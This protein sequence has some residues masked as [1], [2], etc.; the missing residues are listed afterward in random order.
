[1]INH[2]GNVKMLDIQSYVVGVARIFP[3]GGHWGAFDFRRGEQYISII[4]VG[5]QSINSRAILAN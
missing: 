3:V 1:M 4:L 5:A 2:D